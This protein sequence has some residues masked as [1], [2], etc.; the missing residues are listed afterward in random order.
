[1]SDKKLAEI[2]DSLP[3]PDRIL[4][5]EKLVRLERLHKQ[6][7]AMADSLVRILKSQHPQAQKLRQLLKQVAN[8]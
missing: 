8:G 3:A 1:M 7:L 5:A 2:L 4:A 6:D